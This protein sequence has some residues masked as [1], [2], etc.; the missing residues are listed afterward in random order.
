VKIIMDNTKEE[1]KQ[2]VNKRKPS[3]RLN[4]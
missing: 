2:C 4:I 3:T 1:N